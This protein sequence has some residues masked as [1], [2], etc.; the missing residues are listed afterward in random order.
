MHVAP[1]AR[2]TRTIEPDRLARNIFVLLVAYVVA[3]AAS[4]W[5]FIRPV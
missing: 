5:L 4:I 2:T 3:V 1:Q